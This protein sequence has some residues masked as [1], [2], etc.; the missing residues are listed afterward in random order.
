MRVKKRERKKEEEVKW[1]E[2]NE[3]LAM[4]AKEGGELRIDPSINREALK[5]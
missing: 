5:H 3:G 2:M 1:G 4:M